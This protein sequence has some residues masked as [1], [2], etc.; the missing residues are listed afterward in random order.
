[1]LASHVR[2]ASLNQKILAFIAILLAALTKR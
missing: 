1:M 2:N